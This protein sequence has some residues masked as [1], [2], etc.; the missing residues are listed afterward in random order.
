[1]NIKNIIKKPIITEKIRQMKAVKN[2]YAFAVDVKANKAEIKKAVESM[3]NVKVEKVN[4]LIL[5][6][7]KRRLGIRTGEKSDWKK[8]FVYLKKDN[9]IAELEV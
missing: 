1:M 7:K 6:G 8:A 3:F 2:V 9:K 5:Q 4:T